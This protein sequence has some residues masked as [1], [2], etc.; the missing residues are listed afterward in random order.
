M[1]I[2]FSNPSFYVKPKSNNL[3]TSKLSF[4]NNNAS[5]YPYFPEP[6]IVEKSGFYYIELPSGQLSCI[7]K[8]MPHEKSLDEKLNAVLKKSKTPD[9]LRQYYDDIYAAAVGGH[10]T[11]RNITEETPIVNVIKEIKDSTILKDIKKMF[12]ITT[13]GNDSNTYTNGSMAG[14]LC[15]ENSR[16]GAILKVLNETKI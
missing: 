9:K 16:L 14:S 15:S 3:N 8:N 10:E 1:Q 5:A 11:R 2:S 13:K 4:G 7:G 6:K 12:E